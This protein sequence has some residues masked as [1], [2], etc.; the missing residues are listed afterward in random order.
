MATDQEL[1]TNH[2]F[3]TAFEQLRKRF[4]FREMSDVA[5]HEIADATGLPFAMLRTARHLRNALAHADPVNRD[6]LDRYH[7]QLV[8]LSAPSSD[9]Q[10][11]I[12][13][14]G[15]TIGHDTPVDTR[16]YRLHAWRDP[17][18]ERHMLANGFVSIGGE[19]IGDLSEIHDPEVIAAHLC[20]SMPDRT[21]G[22]IRIFVGYWRRFLWDARSGDL[23]VLPLRDETVAI[24]E[25]VGPYHYV[26]DAEPHAR[27]RR[28]VS[29]NTPIDRSEFDDELEKTL[30]GRH[31][32]QE[33]KSPGAVD[34]LRQLASA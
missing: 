5:L 1:R 24:G 13:R 22:A 31:T 18:L 33:F 23:A 8:D 30:K 7:R 9:D 12:P 29:W 19:E 3:V 4:G 14:T 15:T 26:A 34:R 25:F 32:V 17:D 28:V 16:A 2:E 21:E 11:R 20:R 27:H 10:R 6:T